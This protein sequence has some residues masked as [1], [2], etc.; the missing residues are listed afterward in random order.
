MKLSKELN[1]TII[2]FHIKLQQELSKMDKKDLNE[3]NIDWTHLF[4]L[5]GKPVIVDLKVKYRKENEIQ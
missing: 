3:L 5:N 1:K 4:G 2:K